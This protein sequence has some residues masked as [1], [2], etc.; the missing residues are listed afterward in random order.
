M[1]G[2][3]YVFWV[4]KKSWGGGSFSLKAPPVNAPPCVDLLFF[5]YFRFSVF[6]LTVFPFTIFHSR[7]FLVSNSNTYV[8]RKS[9]LE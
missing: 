4:S 5:V 8:V 7:S 3:I 2:S 1:E 6:R 9:F